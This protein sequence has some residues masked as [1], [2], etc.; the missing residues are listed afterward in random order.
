M[1]GLVLWS[2]AKDC[3]AVLWCDDHGD[4]AY[5]DAA[6]DGVQPECSLHAGDMVEFDLSLDD[7]IR[8]AHRPVVLSS[9]AVSGLQDRVRDAADQQHVGQSESNVIPLRRSAG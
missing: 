4:L 9:S 2:D 5:F 6:L 8:R 3:K 7:N 1:I